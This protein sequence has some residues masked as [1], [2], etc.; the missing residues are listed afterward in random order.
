MGKPTI[1]ICENKDTDQL[2]GNREADQIVQFFYLNPKFQASSS[3]LCLYRSVCV[4]PVR[5]PHCWFSHEVAHFPDHSN[6]SF[7]I[8]SITCIYT[9]VSMIEKSLFGVLPE[10]LIQSGSH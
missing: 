1:C 6:C 5:K 8:F 4:G 2:R 7:I 3:F 10:L 9:V